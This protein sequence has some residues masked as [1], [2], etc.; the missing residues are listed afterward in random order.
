MRPLARV[1]VLRKKNVLYSA[2]LCS[3]VL[4]CAL[5]CCAAP[6]EV[7]GRMAKNAL[8]AGSVSETQKLRVEDLMQFFK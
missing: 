5:L 4:C 6:Q 2:L 3:A 1:P 7:K 8:A